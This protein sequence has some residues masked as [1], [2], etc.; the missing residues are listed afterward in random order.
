MNR[1]RLGKP[2]LNAR[3]WIPPRSVEY[4]YYS[5]VAYSLWAAAIGIEVPFV[6]AGLTMILAGYCAS[7]LGTRAK[8]IFHPI[9]FLI[10]CIFSFVLIQIVIHGT[11]MTTDIIR[12]L[13][14]W[15]CG[16]IV[17]QSLSIR[18]RFLHRFALVLFFLG[19]VAIPY[20]TVSGGPLE[21]SRARVD[22]EVSGN[23]THE[24]GLAGWF[25]FCATFFAIYGLESNRNAVRVL[26]WL[27]SAGCWLIIGYTVSRGSL[28]ATALATSFAMRR[29][30]GRGFAAIVLLLLIVALAFESGM[31]LEIVSRYEDRSTLETGRLLLWPHVIERIFASLVFGVGFLNMST[32][33]PEMNQPIST[34]HNTFL[35]FA[36][37]S[38]IIPFAFYIAYWIRAAKR[39]FL[40][41]ER[42]DHTAYQAP[43]LLYVL[44]IFMFGDMNMAPWVLLAL[45]VGG[46]PVTFPLRQSLLPTRLIRKYRS[47]HLIEIDQMSK[48]SIL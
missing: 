14:V 43:F 5:T 7:N 32:F 39:Y 34:P 46:G 31:F 24:N 37:T 41:V 42:N 47:G 21:V 27:A 48:T 15:V 1:R 20:L 18:S 2:L 6:A 25:G 11:P 45:T 22:V 36:L 12:H 33:V 30:I 38:G 35:F 29:I 9:V 13:I 23:L 40:T 19:L 4:L 8:E 44:V 16:L 17:V 26:S 28:L 10:A 3:L